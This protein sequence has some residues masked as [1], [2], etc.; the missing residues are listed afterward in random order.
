MSRILIRKLIWNIFSEAQYIN[1]MMELAD[2]KNPDSAVALS[3]EEMR[4]IVIL[5]S[6]ADYL[7]DYLKEHG[8]SSEKDEIN[9][10]SV[11]EIV[12]LLANNLI[13]EETGY[14]MITNLLNANAGKKNL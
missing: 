1:T 3:Q 6:Q 7:H 10:R 5:L 4:E 11:K 8:V 14:D 13:S 12:Q 9:E 2:R